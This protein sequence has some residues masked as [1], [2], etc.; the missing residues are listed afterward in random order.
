MMGLV[1]P[2]N[3]LLLEARNSWD[4]YLSQE[5]SIYPQIYWSIYV[6]KRAP[7]S[8]SQSKIF[9]GSQPNEDPLDD[10]M[11]R[12]PDFGMSEKIFQVSVLRSLG[13]LS[14]A[15]SLRILINQGLW[16]GA[17][18]RRLGLRFRG[19]FFML[20]HARK[21]GRNDVRFSPNLVFLSG[22]LGWGLARNR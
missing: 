19:A 16:L 4:V 8:L 18:A 15:Q 17:T 10:F 3:E 1:L 5:F 6:S 2:N 7:V 13:K 21:H 22:I 20:N 12:P 9:A 11:N 14:T